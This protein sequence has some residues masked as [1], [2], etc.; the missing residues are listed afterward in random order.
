MEHTDNQAAEYLTESEIDLIQGLQQQGISD[1]RK[2]NENDPMFSSLS[3]VKSATDNPVHHK[4]LSDFDQIDETQRKQFEM[5]ITEMI[6]QERHDR[7]SKHLPKS[8]ERHDLASKNLPLHI[9]RSDIRKE[10]VTTA[11]TPSTSRLDL[12]PSTSRPDT[13]T[14]KK[15]L[16]F[17]DD[18]EKDD[19]ND[20]KVDNV[21]D[22]L[23]GVSLAKNITANGDSDSESESMEEKGLLNESNAYSVKR[24]KS[25]FRK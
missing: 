18:N 15:S 10:P 22:G 5:K 7:T 23:T 13:P 25:S 20:F 19:L 3:N 8:Q 12:S 9:Q 4:S 17:A 24:G 21:N 14:C 6:S 11:N 1:M 2:R 16:G